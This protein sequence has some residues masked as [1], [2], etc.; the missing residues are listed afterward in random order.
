MMEIKEE[1]ILEKLR[2]EKTSMSG[3][4]K[5]KQNIVN[6]EKQY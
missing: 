1:I 3:W 6:F 2:M 5:H 4:G